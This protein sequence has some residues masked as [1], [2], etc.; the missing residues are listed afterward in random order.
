MW[1][2]DVK[3]GMH[4][5]IQSYLSS[6]SLKQRPRPAMA[7]ASLWFPHFKSSEFRCLWLNRNDIRS[8]DFQVNVADVQ[9]RVKAVVVLHIECYYQDLLY[10]NL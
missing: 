2:R 3:M 1:I 9:A 4:N 5:G 7:I 10:S 6:W 8:H